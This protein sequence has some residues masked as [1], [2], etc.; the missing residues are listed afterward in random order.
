MK[1]DLTLE[2]AP[3]MR[4]DNTQ[5]IMRILNG[6]CDAMQALFVGGCVRNW[7]LNKDVYDIDIATRLTPDEVMKTLNA[8]DV[9]VVPTGIDHGTVTAVIE[10]QHFEI[11]TLRHDVQTDG[12]HAQVCFTQSWLEDAKRRDFTMNTLL[13]DSEGHVYDPLG[14]GIADAKAGRVIFVGDASARIAED[15]LRILRV[16]R[17]QAHYGQGE[18]DRSALEACRDEADK[19][20]T[21][22]RERIMQE[23]LKILSVSDPSSV[24]KIM[25]DNNILQGLADTNYQAST[26]QKL[27]AVQ[28]ENDVVNIEARLFVLAGCQPKLFE[29]YMRLSHA[30]KNFII[31]LQMASRAELYGDERA[32]KK[33]IYYH[34]NDLMTQGY[35]LGVAIGQVER[36]AEMI[37]FAQNWQAPKCP[38]TGETLMAEGYVTGPDLGQ[39][40]KRREEEWLDGVV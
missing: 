1:A 23:F 26:L 28:N 8:A 9:K 6:D 16:F 15:Y 32:L 36:S 30:Q 31:K 21:L 34:G 18:M 27:C 12:R 7:I 38:I 39:E 4:D 19:I 20:S 17:F 5:R 29:E 11:T 3:W 10:E 22:S 35:L 37:D 14:C 2:P 40:L 24:L 33:A 13:A 25:F